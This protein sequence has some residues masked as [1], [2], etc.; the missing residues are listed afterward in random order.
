MTLSRVSAQEAGMRNQ[1]TFL[2]PTRILVGTDVYILTSE[3][4]RTLPLFS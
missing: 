4:M 1:T 2:S 3:S